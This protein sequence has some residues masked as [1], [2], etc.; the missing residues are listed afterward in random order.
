VQTLSPSQTSA[1]RDVDSI[2]GTSKFELDSSRNAQLC[3]SNVEEIL[4]YTTQHWR[5]NF[6]TESLT[7]KEEIDP[8]IIRPFFMLVSVDAPLLHRFRRSPR[9][10]LEDF[11]REDDVLVYGDTDEYTSFTLPLCQ[12]NEN[13]KLQILNSFDNIP[14]LHAYL[15]RLN[16]LDPSRLRPS[17][18]SYFMTLASLAAQRS[19]CMKRRV[20]AILVRDHRILATGYVNVSSKRSINSDFLQQIQRYIE[21]T[22][23]L[24][25]RRM[26]S[27]QRYNIASPMYMPPRGRKCNSGGRQRTHRNERSSLLQYVP[28]SEVYDN[29]HSSWSQ[30]GRL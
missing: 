7:L 22:N 26:P 11:V 27:L 28:M 25:R 30:R 12:L 15:D 6:V 29:H 3:F 19:N 5:T 16:L 21:G 2:S 4:D 17:W 13:V 10:N 18:D 9:S 24:Q 20:G 23:E 14:D 8:F 1:S